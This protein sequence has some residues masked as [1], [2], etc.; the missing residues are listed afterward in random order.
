MHGD[1][2]DVQQGFGLRLNRAATLLGTFLETRPR[3]VASS[4]VFFPGVESELDSRRS[5]SDGRISQR[6]RRSG[7]ELRG[8]SSRGRVE[9]RRNRQ[10]TGRSSQRSSSDGR[11]SQRKR[12]SGSELRGWRC[13]GRVEHRRSSHQTVLVINHERH[14][15]GSRSELRRS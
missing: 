11:S 6:K 7:S 12:R 4:E 14:E 1:V 5:I 10:Q 8:W 15:F 3:F 13:R 9:H 2:P